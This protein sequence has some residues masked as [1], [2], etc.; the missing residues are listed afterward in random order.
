[1]LFDDLPEDYLDI[2]EETTLQERLR[3][4]LEYEPAQ[5]NKRR[6]LD[7]EELGS[8]NAGPN[9]RLFALLI[10]EARC[11]NAFKRLLNAWLL[12]KA[13]KI[14]LSTDDP[15]TLMPFNQPLIV[16]DLRNRSRYCFEAKTLV[17]NIYH[18]LR[19]SFGG[20]PK[21][22]S[23]LNPITNLAFGCGQLLHI[24]TECMRFG[25]WSAVFHTF[26]AASFDINQYSY[27]QERPLRFAAIKEFVYGDTHKHMMTEEMA[28]FIIGLA[29]KRNKYLTG[30]EIRRLT[31]GLKNAEHPYVIQWMRL[32]EEYLKYD[33]KATPSIRYCP[34]QIKRSRAISAEANILVDTLRGY[35]DEIHPA[36]TLYVT[37]LQQQHLDQQRMEEEDDEEDEEYIDELENGET[38]IFTATGTIEDT[39]QQL[40]ARI[41]A[42][43]NSQPR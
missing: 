7:E 40:L 2:F 27:L 34:E 17:T 39:F 14:Q 19:Y 31:Y 5:A 20:F 21:P 6:R 8:Q 1:M 23:P 35:L 25:Y 9:D 16:Y 30:A 3:V 4:L 13:N 38:V 42:Y 41:I 32:F 43:N 29:N 26:R 10:V 12:K 37:Q 36:Y 33:L 18:Q 11:R 28:N 15:I 24:F 22:L